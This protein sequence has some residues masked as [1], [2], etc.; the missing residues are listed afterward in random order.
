MRGQRQLGGQRFGRGELQNV[1]CFKCKKFGHYQ[2]HFYSQGRNVDEG[3][4]LLVIIPM[5]M[6]VCLWYTMKRLVNMLRILQFGC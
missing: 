6:A 1:Q 5:N 2:S 3:L 4:V